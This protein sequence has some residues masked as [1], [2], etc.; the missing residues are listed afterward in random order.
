MERNRKCN[1]AGILFT[2]LLIYEVYSYVMFLKMIF[3]FN[4]NLVWN[5][6][7]SRSYAGGGEWVMLIGKPVAICSLVIMITSSFRLTK[8]RIGMRKKTAIVYFLAQ[9][10]MWSG[11]FNINTTAAIF[12]SWT[13]R[14]FLY[15]VWKYGMIYI[16]VIIYLIAYCLY[17]S[18]NK[19]QKAVVP[20][21]HSEEW[22]VDYYKKLM[23]HKVITQKEYQSMV[24]K[25]RLGQL[26]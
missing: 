17:R 19:K 1:I 13:M 3:T 21:T 7:Y 25:I 5:L 10:C 20:D 18:G 15:N 11:T 2:L 23:D 8:V 4:I 9:F 24:E 22:K 12:R 14:A 16:C 6:T 26:M